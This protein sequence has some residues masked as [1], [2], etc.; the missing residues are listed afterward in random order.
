MGDAC[1]INEKRYI[2]IV[3]Y[4]T[5]VANS[6]S[7]KVSGTSLWLKDQVWEQGYSQAR[8]SSR[9]LVIDLLTSFNR[10]TVKVKL[11]YY[12]YLLGFI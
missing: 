12:K 10:L 8:T 1:I 5:V 2:I 6:T 9:R 7:V 11:R 3:N 4:T